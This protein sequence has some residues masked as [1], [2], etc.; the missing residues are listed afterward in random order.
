MD[1]TPGLV[2]LVKDGAANLEGAPRR[3]FMAAFVRLLGDGGQR[4]AEELLSWNRGTIRKGDGELRDGVQIADGRKGNGRASIEERFPHILADLR[5]VVAPYIQVDPTFR[6]ERLYRKLTT[7]EVMGRLVSEKGYSEDTLPCE[8]AL[9]LRLNKLGYFPQRVRK[10]KPKKRSPRP[11]PSSSK[12]RRSTLVPT[13]LE[14][15]SV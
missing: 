5:D 2:E 13:Q 11:T 7:A 1:L 4:T 15:S 9:R 3:R 6:S 10:S 8:E 14:T 12:S